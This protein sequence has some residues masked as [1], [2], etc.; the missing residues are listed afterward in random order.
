MIKWGFSTKIYQFKSR[1]KGQSYIIFCAPKKFQ[2]V[3]QD[4]EIMKSAVA[5]SQLGTNKK[6]P[7][8]KI[9]INATGE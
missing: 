2:D 8:H 4:I 3:K 1:P 6:S 7:E 5:D 9:H